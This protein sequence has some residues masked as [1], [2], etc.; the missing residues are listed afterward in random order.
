VPNWI[1]FITAAAPRIAE[2]Q[3]PPVPQPPARVTFSRALN[4]PGERP[5]PALERLL[6]CK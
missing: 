2:N 3:I 6:H 5:F 1:L 4:P